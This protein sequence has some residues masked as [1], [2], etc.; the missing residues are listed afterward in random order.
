MKIHIDEATNN[1]HSVKKK[2]LHCCILFEERKPITWT[3]VDEK[4]NCT[5]NI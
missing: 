3:I 2:N 5:G 4:S 1:A